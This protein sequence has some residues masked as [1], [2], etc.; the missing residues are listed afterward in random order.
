LSGD[1]H[2]LSCSEKTTTQA[3]HSNPFKL[4]EHPKV[5]VLV[6]SLMLSEKNKQLEVGGQFECDC[7]LTR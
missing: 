3:I 7:N 6:E 2:Q 1:L 5:L 4:A